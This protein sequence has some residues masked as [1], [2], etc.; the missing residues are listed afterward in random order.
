MIPLSS[1]SGKFLSFCERCLLAVCVRVC[2]CPQVPMMVNKIWSAKTQLPYRYYDLP[3]CQPK[4]VR[5]CVY[6]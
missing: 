4:S 2:V 1:A 3:F 6:L 5:V